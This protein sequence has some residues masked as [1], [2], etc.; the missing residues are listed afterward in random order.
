MHKYNREINL[1][2]QKYLLFAKPLKFLPMLVVLVLALGIVFLCDSITAVHAVDQAGTIPL[3]LY[4]NPSTGLHFYTTNIN[5]GNN[6]AGYVTEGVI[7]YVHQNATVTDPAPLYRYFNPTTGAHFY[8]LSITEGETAVTTYG[9]SGE[10][11]AAYIYPQQQAGTI[12][13]YRYY[14][15]SSGDHFYTSDINEGRNAVA[16]DGYAA[17]G[18]TGYVNPQQQAGTIPL[19]RY[20]NPSTSLH[21]YTT[22]IN[23]G[24]NAAGYVS[25]GAT[26]YVY[27]NAAIGDP[28]PLYR[29]FNPTSGVHFYTLSITEGEGAV[30]TNGYSG[31]GIAAYIYPY[32]RTGT[33]PLYYYYNTATGDRFYTT[34]INEGNSAVASSQYVPSFGYVADGITGY[35]NPQQQLP[36][37]N[38][39]TAT[40]LTKSNSVIAPPLTVPQMKVRS[41]PL[42]IH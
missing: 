37:S 20:F 27:Q 28:V 22:N 2:M 33:I 19:Y 8:T 35:I 36:T 29:Y 14:N 7:G 12:P 40:P 38:P 6:A 16:S 41:L 39:V 10:G 21:F 3:Y 30:T 9:Y 15:P 25:E 24:R 11:I 17:E 26:G 13:L 23:E 1:P 5:E 42:P 31:E 34:N 32:Q 4:Y 18:V